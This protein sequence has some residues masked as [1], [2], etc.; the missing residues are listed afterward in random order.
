MKFA[1][2]A[3]SNETW[4]QRLLSVVAY[5][6]LIGMLIGC[7]VQVV[8]VI[9]GDG[10]LGSEIKVTTG[11]ENTNPAYTPLTI[12]P[13]IDGLEGFQ[14]VPQAWAI[15]PNAPAHRSYGPLAEFLIAEELLILNPSNA[16]LSVENEVGFM[17]V[18]DSH[19]VSSQV[20]AVNT[21]MANL[22]MELPNVYIGGI[23]DVEQA[24]ANHGFAGFFNG[25]H[26]LDGT[27]RD[28]YSCEL[29]KINGSVRARIIAQV[30]RTPSN[31]AN[32]A[33]ALVDVA[34]PNGRAA[35][36]CILDSRAEQLVMY[37]DGRLIGAVSTPAGLVLNRHFF[38]FRT[39]QGGKIASASVAD[40]SQV[41]VSYLDLFNDS[42]DYQA[43]T[44]LN[45]A[46]V[47]GSGIVQINT[48]GKSVATSSNGYRTAYLSQ[49]RARYLN[50]S[51]GYTLK[52]ASGR[53]GLV[54]RNGSGGQSGIRVEAY[55]FNNATY[56]RLYENNI[57]RLAVNVGPE[58]A[59]NLGLRIRADEATVT[60][61]GNDVQT[62]G[63][64]PGQGAIGMMVNQQ[65]EIDLFSWKAANQF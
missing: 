42:F 18:Q 32:L 8:T 47:S 39:G 37:Y 21:T 64:N 60:H 55:R 34:V 62:V 25:H 3:K 16:G 48:D 27:D 29:R 50:L 63:I 53:A 6:L 17:R 14:P 43:G 19:L 41:D 65:A 49:S 11:E 38:G 23:L 61:N 58:L 52:N 30:G 59:G 33:A 45:P 5:L 22:S 26:S 51:I 28:F 10:T 1:A 46:W 31:P 12:D 20:G 24:S 7:K 4:P 56:V 36:E 9:P 57:E 15:A 35:V 44:T 54:A 40:L 2:D 13:L